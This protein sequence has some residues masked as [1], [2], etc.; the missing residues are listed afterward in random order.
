METGVDPGSDPF[1][2]IR[3]MSPSV[4][5][6]TVE[7]PSVM[8]RAPIYHFAIDFAASRTVELMSMVFTFLLMMSF[9]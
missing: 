6:P 8:T 3:E 2:T 5:I 4:I 7:E 9:T 1:A